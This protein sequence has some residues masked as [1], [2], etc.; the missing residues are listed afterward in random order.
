M[1]NFKL[2]VKKLGRK[3]I[4]LNQIESINKHNKQIAVVFLLNEKPCK[5]L[6]YRV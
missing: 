4:K 6:T 5:C 1:I 2:N 3:A